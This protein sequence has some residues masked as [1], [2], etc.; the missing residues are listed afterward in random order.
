MGT[1]TKKTKMPLA[2]WRDFCIAVATISREREGGRDWVILL[3]KWERMHGYIR[4]LHVCG[5]ITHAEWQLLSAVLYYA[6]TGKED[7]TCPF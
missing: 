5:R 3:P 2:A 6:W 7:T 4:A 1:N